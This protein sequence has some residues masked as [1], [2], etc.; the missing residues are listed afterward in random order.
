MHSNDTITVLG[1]FRG[2]RAN[3]LMRNCRLIRD[4]GRACG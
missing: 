4:A 2:F 3:Y 1:R